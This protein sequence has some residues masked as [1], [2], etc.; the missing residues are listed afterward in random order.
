MFT[1]KDY[2]DV[3]LRFHRPGMESTGQMLMK[4]FQLRPLS[5]GVEYSKFPYRVNYE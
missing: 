5:T 3:I 4:I 2:E 1:H